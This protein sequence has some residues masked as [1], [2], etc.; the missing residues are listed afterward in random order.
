MSYTLPFVQHRSTRLLPCPHGGIRQSPPG[1]LTCL[2][3][4]WV[5]SVLL[6]MLPSS[7][8]FHSD[9]KHVGCMGSA[10]KALL[11]WK[12]GVF[13]PSC[14]EILVP[15]YLRRLMYWLIIWTQIK[16][17]FMH[18][19]HVSVMNVLS[20]AVESDTVCSSGVLHCRLIEAQHLFFFSS[21]NNNIQ[22]WRNTLDSIS[23]GVLIRLESLVSLDHSHSFLC[24][25]V[26]DGR[27]PR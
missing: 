7:T 24:P 11:K 13:L 10:A 16:V 2:V 15:L 20:C 17:S 22:L 21:K 3:R 18:T 23:E 6:T 14:L 19:H 8:I 1:Q 26:F 9:F 25:C 27:M 12:R 4:R 5:F